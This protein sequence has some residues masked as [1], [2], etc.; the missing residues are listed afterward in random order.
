[1]RVS[2][3]Q[4]VQAD[5]QSN[6]RTGGL[7]LPLELRELGYDSNITTNVVT[8]DLERINASYVQFRAGRG[9]SA[10][11]GTPSLNEW[12]IR[13]P[14]YGMRPPAATDGFMLYVENDPNTGIDDQW[15]PVTVTA[16]ADGSAD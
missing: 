4:M 7:V 3:G 5:M 11:C 16:I 12:R 13:K 8:S 14:V 2:A 9:F 6:V 10:T 1:M 15:I